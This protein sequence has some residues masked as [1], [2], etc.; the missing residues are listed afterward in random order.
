MDSE[1]ISPLLI[2]TKQFSLRVVRMTQAIGRGREADVIARQVLRSGTSVGANYRA[3]CRARST[4]DMIAK[5]KIVEEEADESMYWMELLVESNIMPEKRLLPLMEECNQILA[6]VVAS[7][8]TLRKK[9]RSRR[10]R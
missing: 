10:S 3:A 5:L 6:M 8:L 9:A 7:V 2:R 4:E 1:H